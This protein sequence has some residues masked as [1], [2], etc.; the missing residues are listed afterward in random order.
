MVA[1]VN[2]HQPFLVKTTQINVSRI[3]V[4]FDLVHFFLNS[5]ESAHKRKEARQTKQGRNIKDD[6]RWQ[7]IGGRPESYMPTTLA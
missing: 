5:L 2:P 1:P 4:F 3:V 6:G 7:A